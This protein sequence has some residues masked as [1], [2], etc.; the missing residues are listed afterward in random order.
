MCDKNT[1]A[2]YY[3]NATWFFAQCDLDT[4]TVRACRIRI[5]GRDPHMKIACTQL[6]D[7]SVTG[8]YPCVTRCVR[9]VLLSDGASDP[10]QW[11]KDRLEY[12]AKRT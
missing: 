3:R 6:I 12:P 10:K 2:A 7:A 1:R 5:F 9:R 8:W 4:L 11:V